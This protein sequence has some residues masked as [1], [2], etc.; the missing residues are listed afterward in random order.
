M[1]TSMRAVALTAVVAASSVAGLAGQASAAPVARACP[2]R[3]VVSDGV[4]NNVVAYKTARGN[5]RQGSI[6][7]N[8]KLVVFFGDEGGHPDQIA[9]RHR[10]DHGWVKFPR[11][12]LQPN[13]RCGAISQR[14]FKDASRS[15]Q[16]LETAANQ[17]LQN[18]GQSLRAAA[19]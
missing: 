17:S 5:S 13:G 18:I 11:K 19:R 14:A 7:P 2:Y 12:Y 6:Q 10:T 4:A 8:E 9:G 16:S 1:S 15:F 3:Y